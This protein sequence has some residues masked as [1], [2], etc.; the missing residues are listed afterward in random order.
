MKILCPFQDDVYFSE[1]REGKVRKISEL[2]CT[3]FIDD[4]KEVFQEPKFPRGVK[5]ILFTSGKEGS[6]RYLTCD[7]WYDIKYTLLGNDDQ[8]V[9]KLLA[10]SLLGDFP[11]SFK[12]IKGRGN[13]RVYKVTKKKKKFA[14]KIYPNKHLDE[15]PRLKT[16]FSSLAFLHKNSILNVPK[17]VSKD[18]NLNIGL[19]SWIEGK[20]VEDT[21]KNHLD[22][23]IDFVKL[24]NSLE[25]QEEEFDLASQACL[26]GVELRRQ[27]RKRLEKLISE[28]KD[29]N[30]NLF[31]VKS[32]SPLLKQIE[33]KYFKKWPLSSKDTDLIKEKRI[34]SPS[35]F[36]FHNAL[37]RKNKGLCFLDFDYFGWDDPVKLVSDFY[38]HPAMD[39]T[40]K[41]RNYWIEAT[42]K[43]FMEKDKDFNQRLMASMPFYGL[44]WILIILNEFLDNSLK[45]RRHV[46]LSTEYNSN[47]AKRVQLKKATKLCFSL[48]KFIKQ[49]S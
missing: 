7:N 2:G 36:G 32:F 17:P 9:D 46:R 33:Q 11:D 14:L 12:Q 20:T 15:R 40:N 43:I 8:E 5:K 49:D 30:L 42:E 21:S 26:S 48:E 37:L 13:S 24:L 47:S 10:K 41:Q 45:I 6:A 27:I 23:C 44:R 22:D 3:H 29:K 28:G 34:L 25:T 35:D 16:E 31:L 19:Y 39:L 4:L 1:T 18:I 38:W